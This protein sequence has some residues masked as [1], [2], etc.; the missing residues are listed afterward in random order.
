MN[1]LIAE[2]GVE[3]EN[4]VMI[5]DTTHDILT[6]KMQVL[7]LSVYLLVTTVS[8]LV[9]AGADEIVDDFS[10]L[11]SVIDTLLGELNNEKIL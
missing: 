5:G 10:N 3:K 6:Q 9:N 4:V 7:N 1:E 2:L 8:E 11:P